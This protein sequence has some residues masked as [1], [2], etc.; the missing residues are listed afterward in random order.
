MQPNSGSI[1]LNCPKR[2]AHRP[3]RSSY[4]LGYLDGLSCSLERTWRGPRY[5]RNNMQITSFM[6]LKT[7]NPALSR[8]EETFSSNPEEVWTEIMQCKQEF[9]LSRSIPRDCP[10]LRPEIAESWVRSRQAGVDPYSLD[11]G[12]ELSREDFSRLIKDNSLLLEVAVPLMKAH[13]DFVTW[14]NN[15]LALYDK[16]RVILFLVGH[17]YVPERVHE[18]LGH[19]LSETTFGTCTH[20]LAVR[21]RQPVQL[22]GPEH[23][24]VN[25][26]SQISSSV[27]IFD[28][29]HDV[30][31][32]FV[33]VH[34]MGQNPWL[35]TEFHD[36]LWFHSL[37]WLCSLATA[38]EKQLALLQSNK[39]LTKINKRLQNVNEDQEV[40]NDILNTALSYIDEGLVIVDKSGGIIHC[41]PEGAN[42]LHLDRTSIQNQNILNYFPAESPVLKM[43]FEGNAVECS[44][45]SMLIN[46]QEKAVI[47]S[48]SPILN[49]KAKMVTIAIMRFVLAEKVHRLADKRIATGAAYTF[50][51]ILGQSAEINYAKT[52]AKR[53]APLPQN[54]LLVG[55]SGTG[56]E[57]FAQSI[58]NQSRQN[59]PFVPLNCAAIPRNLVESE[60]FGYEK[61]A[62]T[63]AER[64]GKPGKIELANGGTLFLDEIEDMPYEIQAVLLR[65]LESKKAMRLGG[66]RYRS[67]DFR[68]VAASN[69]DLYEM[70]QKKLFR[71]DLFYRLSAI[72][73]EIPPLRNREGDDM[74]LAEHFIS[75]YSQ[76]AGLIPPTMSAAAKRRILHYR[77]P[78]NVRQ[79]ENAMIYAV[80][81]AEDGIIDLKHL[82][83][84]IREGVGDTE[85]LAQQQGPEPEQFALRDLVSMKEYE[86]A[87]IGSA[88]SKTANNIPAA[89]KLLQISKGTL[90][91]KLRKHGRRTQKKR[92]VCE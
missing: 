48:I 67:V 34:W 8:T 52:I 22:I 43:L 68:L 85:D 71:N 79:L 83:K 20:D 24:L 62:F 37:G 16:N 28:E 89:A 40:V 86:M 58:H 61:G 3:G 74:F 73:L 4:C 76:R 81:M 70:I 88:L 49:E 44:E 65:V 23:Y 42:I 91:R 19:Q 17:N 27:P 11:Y 51:S 29:N 9:L 47:L 10:Y 41:N 75:Q 6:P 31:G 1:R 33:L 13:A 53:F 78:G 60:L 77:W 92:D 84:E 54:I 18:A 30:V 87:A 59:G 38:A 57:L 14:S 36:N 72:K 90:Y 12:R 66:I 21:Y 39:A 63:G 45:E 7:I 46:N 80:N 64:G 82:P 55:E 26:H 25:Y 50:E 56:K 69:R 15:V 2:R 35:K 5:G 32:A